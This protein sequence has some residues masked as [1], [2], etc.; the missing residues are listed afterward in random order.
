LTDRRNRSKL[1]SW[2]SEEVQVRR[3]LPVIGCVLVALTVAGQAAAE[4]SSPATVAVKMTF[5]ERINPSESD[6]PDIAIAF[7]CGTGAVVPFGG[8][9]E[10]IAF[11]SGCGGACDFRQIDLASGSI[12]TDE[13]AGVPSCIDPGC[14]VITIPLTDTIIGGTGQ[15]AGASGS[16]TGSV[17]LSTR[18]GFHGGTAHIVLSGTMTI[19][20]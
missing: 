20:P 11:A 16:L 19:S 10:E 3:F 6:C 9:T 14:A 4:Q 12:F 18:R 7:N 5:E 15:F 1:V 2:G 8:A 13:T 17:T